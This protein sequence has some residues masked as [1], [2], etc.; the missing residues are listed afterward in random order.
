MAK[1]SSLIIKLL[2]VGYCAGLMTQGHT[3]MTAL[4]LSICQC[5]Q[6]EH[7]DGGLSSVWIVFIPFNMWRHHHFTYCQYRRPTLF[8]LHYALTFCLPAVVTAAM[9]STDN[10]HHPAGMCTVSYLGGI[11]R[12]Q[13][14]SLAFGNLLNLVIRWQHSEWHYQA[15]GF[16]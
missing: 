4:W 10:K 7:L 1:Y 6:F 5:G 8:V 16:H 2:L 11:R 3:L 12:P 14:T 13:F 9:T 15:F